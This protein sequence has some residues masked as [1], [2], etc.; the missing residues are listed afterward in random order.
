MRPD[1]ERL[2]T[3][4]GTDGWI[5]EDVY[6]ICAAGHAALYVNDGPWVGFAV[7]QVLPNYTGRRLHAWVVHCV[8]DPDQFI[9]RVRD[10]ARAAGCQKI[11]FSSP[12]KGWMRKRAERLGFAP[13]MVLF[14]QEV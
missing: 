4:C 3:K 2:A 1:L 13:T 6:A 14:E 9:G 12:R 5:P 10:I 7:L 8:V 11:T